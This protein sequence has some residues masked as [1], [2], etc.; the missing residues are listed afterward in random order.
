[1]A[2]YSEHLYFG[3]FFLFQ[4]L[5]P[6]PYWHEKIRNIKNFENLNLNYKK[7]N[8]RSESLS[9]LKVNTSNKNKW[10]FIKRY[11]KQ[12]KIY[13]DFEKH[14]AKQIYNILKELNIKKTKDLKDDI[15]LFIYELNIL[16]NELKDLNSSLTEEEKF[17]YLYTSISWEL[18]IETNINSFFTLKE[19]NTNNEISESTKGK[20][21]KNSV[22]IRTERKRNCRNI[23]RYIY[24]KRRHK[25]KD[26]QQSKQ[27]NNV[28]D[29]KFGNRVGITI[30]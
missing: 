9:E 30:K 23:R 29:N 13:F 10:K 28:L 17:N 4:F 5:F 26:S 24:N 2:S 16:F 27:R 14:T 25:A 18:A 22:T 1:M 21:I 6:L 7:K 15:S 3:N 11:K 8:Q 19:G 20:V 12:K